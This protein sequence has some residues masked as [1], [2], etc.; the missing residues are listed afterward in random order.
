MG[1]EARYPPDCGINPFTHAAKFGLHIAG[2]SL[3]LPVAEAR[4]NTREVQQVRN[5]EERS[6]STDDDFRIRADCVC[7]LRRDCANYLIVN[8]QQQPLARSIESLAHTHEPSS[9]V[10]MKWMRYTHKLRRSRGRVRIP[11]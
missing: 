6:T 3:A 1:I 8:T 11:R 7:P 2:P 5:A 4:H 9:T 10:R